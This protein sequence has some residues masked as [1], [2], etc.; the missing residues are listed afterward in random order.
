MKKYLFEIEGKPVIDRDD[1]PTVYVVS[2]TRD[3]EKYLFKGMV[4]LFEAP[5]EVV[6]GP[7]RRAL[8]KKGLCTLRLSCNDLESV[9]AEDA[10]AL[11]EYGEVGGTWKKGD[12]DATGN[13]LT[14]EEASWLN[15]LRRTML[16]KPS[17]LEIF[18]IDGESLIKKRVSVFR[19]ISW[20]GEYPSDP[21]LVHRVDFVP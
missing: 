9:P 10:W 19:E 15:R 1:T 7:W 2:C 6:E 16:A 18:P 3:G 20:D 4:S 8:D 11:R 17:S 21:Q 12:L 5:T 14:K 13:M